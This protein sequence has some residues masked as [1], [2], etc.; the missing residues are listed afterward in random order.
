MTISMSP[1]DMLKTLVGFPT[2][3]RD[4]NRALIDFVVDYLAGHGIRATV[5]PNESGSKASLYATVGPMDEGGVV[6]SGHTDVVPVDGQVWTSDPFALTEREG[7]LYGRGSSDMKG[8]IAIALALVPEMKAAA[9]KRPIHFALTHD[10]EIGCLGAP[11]LI[12]EMVEAL[13][14]PRAVIVGEPTSMQVVT[15]HKGILVFETRV[16]GKSVHSS[17]IHRGVSATMVAARLVT[18]LEDMMLEAARAAPASSPFVPPYTTIHCGEIH[19]GTAHN[20]VASD[21]HFVTDIRALPG[22]G[23]EAYLQRFKDHVGDVV[24]PQMRAIA[25]DAGIAIHVE[26]NVPAFAPEPGSEAEHLARL[27]TGDNASH[28]VSY[29]TEAGQFQEAGYSVVVCGPGSIDQAHQPDEFIE[30]AQ[31]DAGTDFIRRLIGYLG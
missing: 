25:P 1:R 27:L 24:E 16:S 4:S 6:L 13:P 10:E 22:E 21:C 8:F 17:Q 11:H 18:F 20:I 26:A 31:L 3:S 28:A 29:T 15:G 7:R 5:V 19:G 9:L 23:A 14:R 2:V 12:A 30:T